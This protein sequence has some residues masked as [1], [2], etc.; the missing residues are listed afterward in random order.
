VTGDFLDPD[1]VRYERCPLCNSKDLRFVHDQDW[2]WRWDYVP[3]LNPVIRWM[4]CASCD[5]QMTWGYHTAEALAILFRQAQTTHTPQGM[6]AGDIEA[7]RPIWA[8]VVD[9]VSRECPRGDWLDVGAGSGMLIAL[10]YECGFDVSAI[11]AREEVAA[12]IQA[13]GFEVLSEDV[14]DLRN[15]EPARF[16]VISLCDVLEHVPFPRRV[17][18]AVSY[19]LRPGGVVFISCPNRDSLAWRALNEE[20]VNPYWSEIEHYHNFSWR[21]L[22]ELLLQHG[23][24][25]VSCSINNRYRVGMDVVARKT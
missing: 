17:L 19:A 21:R 18:D 25:A 23:L 5:H 14:T 7:A 6:K 13:R 1:R 4:S 15:G 20:N 10:A 12:A 2:T 11:E 8:K 22:R 9:A 16:D 3:G 24:L